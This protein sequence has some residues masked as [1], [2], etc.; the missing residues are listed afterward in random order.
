MEKMGQRGQNQARQVGAAT[1]GEVARAAPDLLVEQLT[2]PTTLT[3]SYNYAG[4]WGMAFFMLIF[5]LF[6]WIYGTFIR[7]NPFGLIGVSILCT[8]YFFSIFDNMLILTGLTFQ[9][10]YPLLFNLLDKIN[11]K[12]N[13]EIP[14][15]QVSHN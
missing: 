3:N 1:A 10:L 2:V 9:I 15:Q 7:R 11:F 6:P 4:W 8:A 5:W 13:L 12:L 14:V